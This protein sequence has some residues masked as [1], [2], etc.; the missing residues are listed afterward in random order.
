MQSFG[1]DS[2][3]TDD[4][5]IGLRLSVIYPHGLIEERKELPKIDEVAI[6]IFSDEVDFAGLLKQ[7][8]NFI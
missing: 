6:D 2:Q 5:F 8:D 7:L 4:K 1:D 3:Q